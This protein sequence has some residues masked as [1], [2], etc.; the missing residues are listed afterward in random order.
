MAKIRISELPQLIS[1]SL[2]TILVGNDNNVTYKIPL[3]V[4]TQSVV[5]L[6]SASTDNRLDLLEQFE[7]EFIPFSQSVHQEILNATNEQSLSHLTSTAS[8][9]SFTSSYNTDSA[10]FNERI[11]S[12]SVVAG[13]ISS[14][15]QISALGF[16]T[17]V[18]DIDNYVTTASYNLDSA[19]FDS[20]ILAATNEQFLGGFATTSS[21]NDLS[22][23]VDN[24]LDTLESF[25]SSADSRYVLSGSITQTTW[26][27]IANKPNDIISSSTQITGYGFV[28]GSYETTGRGIISSSTQITEYG[29]IS[30]SI[31]ISSLNLFTQSAE[32]RIGNLEAATASY[33]TSLNGAISSSGQVDYTQLQ[34][35]PNNLI[36]S[37]Q[38][39]SD[40]G[41]VTGAFVTI[42]EYNQFTQSI[43]DVTQSFYSLSGSFN[44]IDFT[45]IHTITASYLE[46][47]QS[48][49]SA[50]ASF[51]SRI[52]S[53]QNAT[54]SYL[55]SLDGTISSSNQIAELG[56]IT[57]VLDIDNY[58]TTSSF[59]SLTQSLSGTIS[60]SAQISA[61][62]FIST[63]TDLTALNQFSASQYISNS[64][65]A[66]TGSNSFFGNQFISGNLIPTTDGISYTSSFSLG[67]PTNAWKDIY[68]ST[69]S[70]H[71][72]DSAGQ[73]VDVISAKGNGLRIGNL[74]VD[75]GITGSLRYEYLVNTPTL[76][77]GAAQIVELGYATTSSLNTISASAWG[78]YT[79]A[80][81][82]SS[83]L[84]TSISASNYTIGINSASVSSISGA[85]A[86]T[87]SNLS[88]SSGGASVTTSDTAP[89]SP[90]NGDLWWKSN[91]GNL[92][93]YYDSYWVIATDTISS[94]PSGV[95]S[96]SAQ[97]TT[98]GFATT[99][100]N[101]FT[102]L[103]RFNGQVTLGAGGGDEGGELHFATAET[104]TTLSGS[105]VSVDIYRDRLRIFDGAGGFKGAHLD[106]SKLP[107]G[108]TAELMWKVSGFVNAGTF[109]TLDNLKVSVTTGGS[110]GLSVGAVST[111]FTANIAG[112]YGL[113]GGG[114]GYS[115][116]N[117]GYTTTASTS[118]FSWSFPT[119]GDTSQYN[120]LDKTNS[121]FYRVTLMIGA[122]Y[123]NNFISIERLY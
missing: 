41:F 98:A 119:E 48:Y 123:N 106:I 77:S 85:F 2:N 67:S 59:N 39:I 82:Y 55:T 88:L 112:W 70:I 35:L 86:T 91:D 4:L 7:S 50:S 105:Y 84:A 49:Y 6:L 1:G 25:S 37:S 26:D 14:S 103:N 114:N 72:I 27:N 13:T 101:T 120:I 19:S 79:S 92:Y 8:F 20:R 99:G 46:F 52:D 22:T 109:L 96:S 21:L 81:S 30:E 51:D 111:N 12:G 116:N 110:R 40:Y 9:N 54:S 65:F 78:A 31:D 117:I 61:F 75:N 32:Q 47:T 90:T 29:F 16:I 17:G 74:N 60:S 57:G 71:F 45:G 118:A 5:E 115:A 122:A 97:I 33:L 121:R 64:Y 18:V 93:V 15:A 100:S 56:F 80:S 107:D 38:Q 89:A 73:V 68:V 87:I 66:T 104:N 83:S 53:L 28:S 3:S 34:N 62:G 113:V 95:V 108:I 11:I 58:V 102:G 23:S 10:S 69:G 44:S 24:R 42:N 94:L 63:S 76:I 43:Y 36:S